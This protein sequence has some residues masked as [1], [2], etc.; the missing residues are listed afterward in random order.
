MFDRYFTDRVMLECIERTPAAP[1]LDAFVSALKEGGYSRVTIQRYVRSA[2]HLSHWQPQ[3]A[4]MLTDLDEPSIR[5]FKRHLRR[6]RCQ[7]FRRVNEHDLRGARIFLRHLHETSVLPIAADRLKADATVPALF[8]KFCD[9]MRQHRG[10]R[11]T[12]LETYR[13]TIVDAL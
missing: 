4:Q 3:R 8:V 11:D 10:T 9:W 2:A 5:E 6:C 7:A 1:Y 13:R 12:T